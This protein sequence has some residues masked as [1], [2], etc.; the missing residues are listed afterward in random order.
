MAK[1]SYIQIPAGME[2][3]YARGLQSGDRFQFSRIRIKDMFLSRSRVKGITIKSMLTQLAPVWAALTQ[4][5]RDDWEAAGLASNLHGWKMFVQDT[6]ARR[7]NGQSGY[8]TPNTIYQSMVGRITVAAPATGLQLEQ[9]HPST[10][11]V[12]KKVTGTKSQY[13]P[14]A[15]SEPITLPLTIGI[16]W[17]SDLTAEG[18]S[19][20]ARFF[21]IVYSSYQG[22]DIETVLEIPFGLSDDWTSDTATL[23]TVL[24]PVR[25]YS[26]FIEVYNARGD[27]YFDNINITHN[28]ENWTR[29]PNCNNISQNF[30]RAFFQVARHWVATNPADGTDYGSVYFIP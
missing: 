29:D 20:R 8:A 5:E 26:A 14:Q 6:A 19:P 30:T 16:S 23:S 7:R 18:A 28:G 25:G 22:R 27:L 1:V 12:Q 10:Y 2:T 17:K 9:A 21:C 13:S 3:Q 4:G 24:G 11:F 15:V